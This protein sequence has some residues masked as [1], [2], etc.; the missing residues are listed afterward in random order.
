MVLCLIQQA[1]ETYEKLNGKYILLQNEGKN[2]HLSVWQT[3][4]LKSIGMK[5]DDF[6]EA[7]HLM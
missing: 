7:Y 5:P 2:Y 4:L 3:Q 6:L 1:I